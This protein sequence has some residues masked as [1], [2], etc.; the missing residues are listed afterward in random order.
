[1]STP[2]ANDLSKVI[3]SALARK[4]IYSVY[5]IALVV[6]G[7]LQVAYGALEVG[8]P[9]ALTVALSV[10]VYL[11]IPVGALAAVNTPPADATR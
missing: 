1:M 11:G 7:A 10:L 9:E 8:Q 2:N 4:I 3:T 5:V 6:A